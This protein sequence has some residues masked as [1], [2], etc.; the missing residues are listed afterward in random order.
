MRGVVCGVIGIGL[1]LV[2][3]GGVSWAQ[4][5]S[6]EVRDGIFPMQKGQQS[7]W[8][9]QLEG[10]DKATVEKA[11]RS[12]LKDFGGKVSSKK[13]EWI[14]DD[15]VISA[16]SDHPLDVYA[17]VVERGKYVFVYVFFDLG[18][19]FLNAGQHP[20]SWKQAERLVE[21]LGVQ[22]YRQALEARL[23]AEENTLEKYRK[24]LEKLQQ[25]QK[26]LENA[27]EECEK[28]IEESRKKLA[29]NEQLQ[30]EQKKKIAE[31]NAKVEALRKKLSEVR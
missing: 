27:I 20:Q 3:V 17:K 28:T 4:D 7:G 31:Q 21:R 29:E 16:I 8:Q 30:E 6:Y 14:V 5:I 12:W 10:V 9:I 18:G 26:K 15:V 13:G 19:S 1:V 11:V 25:E 24:E 22:L 23:R 2:L